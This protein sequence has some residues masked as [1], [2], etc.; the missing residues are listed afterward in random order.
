MKY[1]TL[2]SLRPLFSRLAEEAENR[3][4]PRSSSTKNLHTR[5]LTHKHKESNIH[6]I[7]SLSRS[8]GSH[9]KGYRRTNYVRGFLGRIT[10]PSSRKDI[11]EMEKTLFLAL[12]LCVAGARGEGVPHQG[13][14]VELP[15]TTV[16]HPFRPF[17]LPGC[18]RNFFLVVCPEDL[19][20]VVLRGLR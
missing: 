7:L 5:T 8:K 13:T 4:T 6:P 12:T 9:S 20:L 14:T 17:V 19:K 3:R 16:P 10:Y 11:R 2:I 1:S 18:S 15:P